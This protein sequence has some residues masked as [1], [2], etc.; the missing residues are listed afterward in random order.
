MSLN[1]VPIIYRKEVLDTV[2]DRRTLISMIVLPVAAMPLLLFVLGRF[3]TSADR[4]AG[5]EALTIAVRGGDALPGLAQAL[6]QSGFEF[7]VSQD[8]RAAVERKEIAAGL[9]AVTAAGSGTELRIY[10]DDTRQASGI[11]ARK[12]RSALDEF[13]ARKIRSQLRGFGVPESVLTPFV[14]KT[15]SVAPVQKL[16]GLF[17]GSLVTYFVVFLMFT[18]GMYPAIDLTAGEK[19]RRTLEVYLASPA[20]RDAIVLGKILATTTAVLMTALLSVLSVLISIRYTTFGESS[21]RWQAITGRM[22]L[23]AQTWGLVILALAPTA[24]LAASL[25][26]AIALLAKSFKEAQSYLTPVIMAVVCPLVVG[27]LPGVQLTPVLALVPVF[28]ICQLI[29]EIF[30]GES[31]WLAYAITMAANIVY[32]AA[33]FCLAVR[34][35]KSERVLFRT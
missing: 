22:P 8:L 12:I 11:A 27:M 25:M 31:T 14:V 28:N 26:I 19:E 5:E 15:V 24:V 33:A 9:E 13:K 21:G 23:D 30:V 2:R 32:A 17:W 10:S 16:A 35:F 20:G 1:Q 6:K 34:V 18:G 4:K 7:A 29:K 3:I